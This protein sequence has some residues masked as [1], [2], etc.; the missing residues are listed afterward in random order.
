MSDNP[1]NSTVTID[2]A[3]DEEV[4]RRIREGDQNPRARIRLRCGET[5]I[6]THSYVVDYVRSFFHN[7]LPAVIHILGDE[8]YRLESGDSSS[9]VI[10]PESETAVR[11]TMCYTRA[12]A[13]DPDRRTG[14]EPSIVIEST[15]LIEEFRRAAR[16]F[17]ELVIDENERLADELLEFER[18]RRA[19]ERIAAD[20]TVGRSS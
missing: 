6:P 20:L 11:V 3:Y 8:P 15:A 1:A 4:R 9:L 19:T 2:L 13:L 18:Y 14:E 16:E 17:H 10:E 12:S 7:G 5:E